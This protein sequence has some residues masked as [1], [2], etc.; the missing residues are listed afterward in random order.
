MKKAPSAKKRDEVRKGTW[1]ERWFVL[2]KTTLFY[3]KKRGDTRA[4]GEIDLR[5]AIIEDA[6]VKTRKEFT[7]RI[8][9]A[10]Q[11]F[12]YLQC[13]SQSEKEAWLEDIRAA[14]GY[15]EAK[16]E[17]QVHANEYF[18]SFGVLK[19]GLDGNLRRVVLIPDEKR[20]LVHVAF[21][22]QFVKRYTT[23]VVRRAKC[24]K[25]PTVS[26]FYEVRL[27]ICPDPR[28]PQEVKEKIFYVATK[29][30]A[31]SCSTLLNNFCQGDRVKI[32]DLSRSIPK[33][34]GFLEMQGLA[35]KAWVRLW[36]VLVEK[37]CLLY[38]SVDDTIP[39]WIV[40]ISG[41]PQKEGRGGL[42]YKDPHQQ[43]NFRFED[44]VERDAWAVAFAEISRSFEQALTD[45]LENLEFDK[46]EED[47]KP[48]FSSQHITMTKQI[49][50]SLS[51]YVVTWGLGKHG[52]LGNGTSQSTS[53]PVLTR[54]LSDKKVRNISVGQ[55]FGV[56][57]TRQGA[58]YSWGTGKNG[59]LGL[60]ESALK[61]NYPCLVV[62]LRSTSIAQVA[63]GSHHVLGQ[64]GNGQIF[65]WGCN[66]K[67]QLG[68]GGT[69]NQYKPK[70]ISFFRDLDP[71][72]EMPGTMVIQIAASGSHSLALQENG[73]AVYSWGYNKK[74]QLGQGAAAGEMLLKPKAIQMFSGPDRRITIS[75]L[76]A[77]KSN[78][79]FLAN[80]GELFICGDNENGQL[81]MG[82]TST[83]LS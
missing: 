41:T 4:K 13:S 64:T 54:L 2:K 25:E 35:D 22:Q 73:C 63:C 47:I 19:Q 33:Q 75:V 30:E 50:E 74:G 43:W 78:S 46:T 8:H 81:G 11:V 60:G 18:A 66:D 14:A 15:K 51:T 61:K 3:Y 7:I 6:D 58:C 21:E 62:S 57:V 44:S 16:V 70:I 32:Q 29:D 12:N 26:S 45:K 71:T 77:G 36:A 38:N 52:Q 82:D 24:S 59:E 39:V 5:A 53:F 69:S 72:Q 37:R 42:S 10:S 49:A 48:V 1:Q 65:S 23:N 67:G 9:Q 76:A 80:S 27:V 68:H 56:A 20:N 79:A 28:L 31:V 40:W 83:R 17:E 55:E 34:K